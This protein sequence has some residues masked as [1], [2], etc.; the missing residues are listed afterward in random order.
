MNFLRNI[1]TGPDNQTFELAHVLWA[2]AVISFIGMAIFVVWQTKAYPHD[3][4]TDFLALN[5]GGAAG[6]YARAKADQTLTKTGG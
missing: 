3:F 5:G 6:A 1:F 4:G 2:I